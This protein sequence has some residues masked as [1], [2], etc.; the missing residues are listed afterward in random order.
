MR[1]ILITG[2][3]G[4]IG[5][6]LA[7][8]LSKNKN[9]KIIALDRNKTLFED[10]NI[11]QIVVDLKSKNIKFPRNIDIVIHLACISNDPSVDLNPALGNSINFDCF[12]VRFSKYSD[13]FL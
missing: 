5:K 3:S 6:Y 7:I 13:H 8:S 9:N 4:F 2:T 10:K 12:S 11:K 1:K